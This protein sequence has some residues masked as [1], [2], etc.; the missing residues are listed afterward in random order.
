M[1]VC[2]AISEER[3]QRFQEQVFTFSQ[4]H[5]RSLPWRET[6]DPYRILVSEVMLQQT[7]VSRVIPFYEHWI[8]AWPSVAALADASR[9][10]VLRAWMGLGYNSRGVNLHRAAGVIVERFAGD[11]L[12]AMRQYAEVPGVGRYTA[13][14]V[15][16]FAANE[17]LVTVDTNIRRILRAEFSLADATPDRD[18]WDLAVRCLPRGRSREWH[19][20]LMDYGALLVTARRTG[21]APRTRQSRFEGSDRQ[22]RARLLRLLLQSPASAVT[23]A[24]KTATSKKRI[25]RILGKMSEEGLVVSNGGVYRILE[26]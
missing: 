20:A 3:I 25:R 2:A 10:S 7:Q 1:V 5:G 9:A 18:L 22:V 26:K 19:N 12:E 13:Q 23:L 8:E 15:R 16:I 21:I 24:E 6:T 17:D 4:A 11:V 14:A